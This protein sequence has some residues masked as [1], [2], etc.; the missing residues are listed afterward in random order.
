M[1]SIDPEG[2]ETRAL[3]ALVDLTGR[4]VLEIGAGYG[5][6]TWRLAAR[7]KSVVALDVSDRDIGRARSELAQDMRGRV[8]LLVADATTY[9]YP[10]S[11]FDV[12]V[13]SHS[14]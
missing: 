5:R 7:A 6:L 12:A 13:L 4:S 9:R 8:R 10:R 3:D 11:R 2:N 14:L 1:I